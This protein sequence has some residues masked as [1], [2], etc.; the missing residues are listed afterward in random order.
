[1]VYPDEVIPGQDVTLT[2]LPV[3]GVTLYQI[4]LYK[5][6]YPFDP[7][8]YSA[9]F[10][11]PGEITVPAG[12]FA[13]EG[14][15]YFYSVAGVEGRPDAL[16]QGGLSFTIGKDAEGL[17]PLTISAEKTTLGY[18]EEVEISLGGTEAEEISWMLYGRAVGTTEYQL[19]GNSLEEAPAADSPLTGFTFLAQN[20]S[21]G[22]YRI[23]A[24]AKVN[25]EWTAWSNWLELTCLPR[26]NIR[27][28]NP[29]PQVAAR[30]TAGEP[31]HVTWTAVEL[32]EKYTVR[33]SGNGTSGSL[34]TTECQADIPTDGMAPGTYTVSVRAAAIGYDDDG[35]VYTVPFEI[36]QDPAT[37]TKILTLPAS[38]TTIESQAFAD[39]TNVEAVRIP[40][41][42]TAIAPDAFS[43]SDITILAPAGSY[44]AD[45]AAANSYPL[46]T[47]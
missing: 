2:L 28:A 4:N 16:V 20:E 37:F 26:A 36:T 27:L 10:D 32:A 34:T 42:V 44:A 13:A 33:W 25:G 21:G 12:Y 22:Q 14:S 8:V 17:A 40:A 19:S 46:V 29:A 6:A 43:G 31:A 9:E 45:W 15:Y 3:E 11:E 47:E 35:H 7:I 5:S 30:V 39:L 1:M 18:L 41:T 23:R 38:L 24:K